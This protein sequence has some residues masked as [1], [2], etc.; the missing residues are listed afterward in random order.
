[1][2]AEGVEVWRPIAGARQQS[3]E[4]FDVVARFEYKKVHQ[5]GAHMTKA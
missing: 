3:V 4:L 1:M 2:A 5:P